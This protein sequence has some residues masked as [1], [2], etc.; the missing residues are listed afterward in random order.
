MFS[1]YVRFLH[2]ARWPLAVFFI[3]LFGFSLAQARHLKLKS[4]FKELLPENFQSVRDLNRIVER[5]GSTASLIIVVESEDPRA[6]IRF[7]N[8]LAAKLKEYPPEF[9]QRVEYN[10]SETKTF[11]QKNKYLYM[12]LADIQEIY[13]RLE[14]RIDQEKLKATGIYLDFTTKEEREKESTFSDL[15]ERY[16]SK[17]SHY[18]QYLDGYF[19][20]NNQKT[21]AVIIRPPGSATG[22]DF[23]K[24]LIDRIQ[25]TISELNPSRYHPSMKV[26]FTGKFR[27]VLF[28]YQAL[29][30]DIA[31]TAVLC[32][33]LVGLV[34]LVYYRKVRM[35]VLMAW[36][37]IMGTVWTFAITDLKIGYLTTQTAFLG[38]III[39][40]GI[41][42]SLI[43]MARYLEER[44]LG[45]TPPESL[46]ISIPATFTGTFA[47]SLTTSVAF[48]TL[49]L[50][51]I[52]GFSH[53]GFIGGLGMFL[54]WIA[55]YTALPVFLS[56]SEEIWPMLN[57][58]SVPNQ[59]KEGFSL[60]E[61]IVSRLPSWS[62]GLIGAGV[63]FSFV[64][65]PLL[66]Y[67]VPRSLEYDFTKLRVKTQGA[68]VSEEAI[69]S[70]KVKRIFSGSQ[71]PAV[72]VTDQVGDVIPLC[73]EI[74]RKNEMDLPEKRVV[75]S[76]KSLFSYVPT[77]QD[78]KIEWF[79]K[80]RHLLGSKSLNF[81]NV[82]QKKKIEEFKSGF[83]EGHVSV[84]DLPQDIVKNFTEKNGD[85]GK[86][87]FVYPTDKAP[88]WNGKNL[89]HF[90]EMIRS[91]QLPSGQVVTASGDSVIFADLL[92]SV[93]HDGPRAT[94][95]AFLAV[96]FVVVLI[97]RSRRGVDYILGNLTVGVL[98]MG[99][100]VA[101][102]NIKINFFNFIA[103]PTTFGIGVDYGCNIY[104]RYRLESRGL[105]LRC[106]G[107][108][109]GRLL[110]AL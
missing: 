56:I 90:A 86:I 104:Q 64:S 68:E 63:F 82:D 81:L 106:C 95:F 19:F 60:M 66:I 79:K 76:C 108:R 110:F 84:K 26:G 4:D 6:S 97:F 45:K 30:H 12:E 105:S 11:F 58:G 33:G 24:K 62:K 99:A 40:N 70:D 43:L 107:R 14:R 34:V 65:I 77:D 92:R 29:I 1:S 55:T 100:L 61:P 80:I 49:L 89:I 10:V 98:W 28:E 37:T 35:V 21:L 75:D 93:I 74:N 96:C 3:L 23:S 5:V 32:I 109:G 69:L 85:V 46:Q 20:D 15:E 83:V 54:C 16:K 52:R 18:D 9:I 27:R 50:T 78:A 38:S 88:L 91:N 25:G 59:E 73:Q 22:V 7:A 57:S 94:A 71:T 87:V 103:I 72:L 39:G 13:H 44:R 8:D 36:T 2:K 41:N 102:L 47:S 51:H 31:S 48:A 53:F 17:A 42:Y 67:F 101:L